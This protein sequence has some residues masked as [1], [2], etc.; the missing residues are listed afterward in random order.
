[1]LPEAP[2]PA[3]EERT[4]PASAASS[5]PKLANA[6]NR[7]VA[8]KAFVFAATSPLFKINSSSSLFDVIVALFVL[9]VLNTLSASGLLLKHALHKR[10][11]PLVVVALVFLNATEQF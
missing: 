4:N 5:E 1:L 11:L 7:P 2:A 9:V 3:F 8:L 6:A 10:R